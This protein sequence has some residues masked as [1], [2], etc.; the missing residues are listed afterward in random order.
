MQTQRVMCGCNHYM[1]R[2]V[3]D[4]ANYTGRT[5]WVQMEVAVGFT[6]Q[7][8]NIGVCLSKPKKGVECRRLYAQE[9]I[10]MCV[11]HVGG[12]LLQLEGGVQ[13]NTNHCLYI[14]NCAHNYL[15]IAGGDLKSL[16]NI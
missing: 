13:V 3:G 10:F 7:E 9:C 1:S 12:K 15:C 5:R 2:V 4:T 11:W 16:A 8:E 14:N 6:E